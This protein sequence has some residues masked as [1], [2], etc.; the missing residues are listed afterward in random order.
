MAGE[1]EN[2]TFGGIIRDP[3]KLYDEDPNLLQSFRYW[4]LDALRKPIDPAESNYLF[5]QLNDKLN[6]DIDYRKLIDQVI[7][8][9]A[10][11]PIRPP[12]ERD[13]KNYLD[14][15]SNFAF[16]LTSEEKRALE[17][18]FWRQ[19]FR[20]FKQD[21]E[22]PMSEI[23]FERIS[24]NI[25]SYFNQ[26]IMK[27][28]TFQFAPKSETLIDQREGAEINHTEILSW[29]GRFQGSFPYADLQEMISRCTPAAK[30]ILQ[31]LLYRTEGLD[32][33]ILDEEMQPMGK[34]YE[35]LIIPR[36]GG[37]IRV[38][39]HRLKLPA[40]EKARWREIFDEFRIIP[41]FDYFG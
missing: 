23:L 35:R 30:R 34:D 1:M 4:I 5:G 18:H 12:P 3:K 29:L 31:R 26:R 22:G 25:P 40:K 39:W 9:V 19:V 33:F 20:L 37:Y 28:L 2:E 32:Y 6:E 21:E 36:R 16:V 27:R 41:M 17:A 24:D 15:C 8:E 11:Y 14:F 7:R 13:C 10:S 38:M